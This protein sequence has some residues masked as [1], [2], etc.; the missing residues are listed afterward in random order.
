M[1]G[2]M[3]YSCC[4]RNFS[5]FEQASAYSLKKQ[6]KVTFGQNVILS[7]DIN[8]PPDHIRRPSPPSPANILPVTPKK[9]CVRTLYAIKCLRKNALS[10]KIWLLVWSDL[11]ATYY[12]AALF[13]MFKTRFLKEINFYRK[14]NLF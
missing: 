13:S 8:A 7:Y 4:G 9:S 12:N 11:G 6:C 2:Q 5:T 10:Y 1:D 14:I 3:H